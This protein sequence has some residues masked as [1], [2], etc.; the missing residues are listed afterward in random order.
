MLKD[1]LIRATGGAG[2]SWEIV[3][4]SVTPTALQGDNVAFPAGYQAGD[5]VIAFVAIDAD[6]SMDTP[7]GWRLEIQ[8]S[9]S[10]VFAAVLVLDSVAAQ[11]S[12]PADG[13]DDA[14]AA[15]ILIVLR[16]VGFSTADLPA[17]IFEVSA[18]S[19]SSMPGSPNPPAITTT[20]DNNLIFAFGFNGLAGTYSA[21]PS[22]FT[23][24][25]QGGFEG[26][27]VAAVAEQAVAGLID[28]SAFS[29]VSFGQWIGMTVSARTMP[30]IGKTIFSRSFPTASVDVGGVQVAAGASATVVIEGGGTAPI[31]I[32]GG[33]SS[34]YRINGGAWTSASGTASNGDVIEVRQTSVAGTSGTTTASTATITVGSASATF[35]VNTRRELVQT[36]GS[37]TWVVPA[38]VSSFN[39]VA[40]GAG[41]TSG[42]GFSQTNNHRGGG[43]GGGGALVHANG[44][45]V[46]A[47]QSIVVTAGLRSTTSGAT[48]QPSEITRNG[49]VVI[50]ALG[51][52]GGTRAFSTTVGSGGA[53]GSA[54]ASIGANK[55]SGGNGG[56]GINSATSTHLVGG[57]GGGAGGYTGPGTNGANGVASITRA[58]SSAATGGASSG[59][60]SG[61][62][63][64]GTGVSGAGTSGAAA[65]SSSAA[66]KEGSPDITAQN[67][68]TGL[69]SSGGIGGLGGGGGGGSRSSSGAAGGMGRVRIT[70]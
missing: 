70:W 62:G 57:G 45:S 64:G 51:G 36:S 24:L 33:N 10:N 58:G 16:P 40:V 8:D 17:G 2:A 50:S 32:S 49:V 34:Q 46:S 21:A 26:A 53:G 67:G 19:S 35:R 47:G 68:S 6:K 28:P 11:S 69:S 65:T 54:S 22:G 1:K 14:M 43:G 63:G 23:I 59:G 18:Q 42:A 37:Q 13:F 38:G 12:F 27:C 61:A 9:L 5:A 56:N 30:I 41:G 3:N 4:S 25:R 55:Q 15:V 66:G 20:V 7:N 29:G 48:G 44:I 31:S 60:G 52:S 39:A